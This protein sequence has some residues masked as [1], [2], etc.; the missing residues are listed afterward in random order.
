MSE[1]GM[2]GVDILTEYKRRVA[3]I[4]TANGR[5]T[6]AGNEIY[7]GWLADALVDDAMSTYPFIAMQPSIDSRL[8]VKASGTQVRKL[9]FHVILVDTVRAG[10]ARE[11]MLDTADL[12]AVLSDP[13]NSN[14]LGGLALQNDV[15]DAEYNIPAAG[16]HVAWVALTVAAKYERRFT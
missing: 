7:E 15:G 5:H 16:G 9:E 4:T 10:I 12:I 3:L 8:T 11:L 6:D 1:F 2:R 13:D 14:P